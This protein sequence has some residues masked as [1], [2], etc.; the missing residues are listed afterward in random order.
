ML[1]KFISI[2]CVLS[3]ALSM[4]VVVYAEDDVSVAEESYVSID[5]ITGN[6][7]E[8]GRFDTQSDV[9][10][11]LR[12]EGKWEGSKDF[13]YELDTK[14]TY[15]NSFGSLKVTQ[16][17]NYFNVRQA[18]V[19]M[20]RNQWY[21]LTGAIKLSGHYEGQ[22]QLEILFTNEDSYDKW[23]WWGLNNNRTLPENEWF[24]IDEY[25]QTPVAAADKNNV[26][27]YSSSDEKPVIKDYRMVLRVKRGDNGQESS[28]STFYL[29]ELSLTP[30]NGNMRPNM[31]SAADNGYYTW[32]GQKNPEY[33]DF[34]AEAEGVADLVAAG[35][36][37]NVNK[38]MRIKDDNTNETKFPFS[39]QLALEEAT[40]YDV[41]FWV[42]GADGSEDKTPSSEYC[43]FIPKM[44]STD[45][46]YPGFKTQWGSGWAIMGKTY[47]K[48]G[49]WTHIKFQVMLPKSASK[50]CDGWI[51]L[52]YNDTIAQ[53]DAGAK[54]GAICYIAEYS[55]KKSDNI[56][57]NP[58]FLLGQSAPR[59]PDEQE[60]GQANRGYTENWSAGLTAH[61]NA[62]TGVLNEGLTYDGNKTY[63]TFTITEENPY[64][65]QGWEISKD[66]K[67]NLSA[68]I[69]KGE[70]VS[71][72]PAFV[73]GNN[74]VAGKA[75]ATRKGWTKIAA[76]N[77]V[78]SVSGQQ[79]LGVTL[80]DE[81]NA[82]LT[83]GQFNLTD[84]KVTEAAEMIAVDSLTIGELSQDTAM[85]V[86]AATKNIQPY[87][88]VYQ[89]ILTD[90]DSGI[91]R[92]VA[93][94]EIGVGQPIPPLE[95]SKLFG[96]SEITLT[97]R[98][99]SVY[100]EWGTT[101]V[102][103]SVA[104]E[105]VGVIP[106][107]ISN[108][109]IDDENENPISDLNGEDNFGEASMVCAYVLC[110]SSSDDIAA[111]NVFLAAYDEHDRLLQLK[112]VRVTL[113]FGTTEGTGE[114][115]KI[116]VS[117]GSGVAKVVAY[118]WGDDMTA[119]CKKVVSV[120]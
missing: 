73:V 41:S 48:K 61:T 59:N 36:F 120:K 80:V 85:T 46:N 23:T 116:D 71:G 11:F 102:S 13:T 107:A 49:E 64:V 19:P 43:K 68:W 114:T 30:V 21:H 4:M 53:G 3:M 112:K 72:T 109:E 58:Y 65:Y 99:F 22:T 92:V 56:I 54:N 28:M 47:A 104:V 33:V 88:G 94:G 100:G 70:E 110:N 52:A 50:A 25:L 60:F 86:E 44:V 103:N 82:F 31:T 91:A 15:N 18:I 98:P 108:L 69:K 5:D 27:S 32:G 16:A 55:I 8:F 2:I 93:S 75:V 97:F 26:F 66:R 38:V 7:I 111:A 10:G 118:A 83:A 20:R 76:E 79:R 24:V 117:E 1:K 119:L 12:D 67:Y 35:E 90:P 42:K 9:D 45:G 51:E 113:G 77:Y 6:V 115:E 29:D 101:K 62:T 34:D 57:R 87:A 40:P 95:Y 37:P 78:P 81:N 84:F 39:Q 106:A 96:G 105:A 89:Y 63:G 17:K 74:V 14:N